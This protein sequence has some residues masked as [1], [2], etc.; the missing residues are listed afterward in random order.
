[1]GS[2]L[3]W[4]HLTFEFKFMFERGIEAFTSNARV[5]LEIQIIRY[6]MSSQI[7]YLK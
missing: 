3:I 4:D 6:Q 2:G 5:F 7:S 1:M